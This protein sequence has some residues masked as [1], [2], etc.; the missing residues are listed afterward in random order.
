MTIITLNQETTGHTQALSDLRSQLISDGYRA[1]AK[2]HS[3]FG[4]YA[5]VVA[6]M[7]DRWGKADVAA[8]N[9]SYE[10]EHLNSQADQYL[11]ELQQIELLAV[12][13]KPEEKRKRV[14]FA[15]AGSFEDLDN[16][17]NAVADSYEKTGW[18]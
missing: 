16:H 7:F 1:F 4:D 14:L 6:L 17:I 8:A 3:M 15:G 13:L 5:D 2:N 9:A 12:E 10:S 18:A 11:A